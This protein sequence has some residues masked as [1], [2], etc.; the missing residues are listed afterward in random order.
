MIVSVD[1][2]DPGAAMLLGLKLAVA[3]EGSPDALSETEELKL[4]ETV[5]VTVLVVEEACATLTD[6]GATVSAKSPP[7]GAVARTE[8]SS[9]RN[10]V[11]MM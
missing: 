4:P 7:P 10:V 11:G 9:I 1:D 5:V 2:P 3:P 6:E 8:T